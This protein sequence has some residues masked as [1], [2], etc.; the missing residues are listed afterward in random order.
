[1]CWSAR[2]SGVTSEVL[3]TTAGH[4]VRLDRLDRR[5]DK[6]NG[7]FIE[8]RAEFRGLRGNVNELRDDVNGMH[9]DVRELRLNVS[10]L[11]S[12]MDQAVALLRQNS[13]ALGQAA[14]GVDVGA[15]GELDPGTAAE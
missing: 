4:T 14:G 13:L 10:G 5:L 12:S 15:T 8:L 1:M 7:N 11:Q 3:T 6:L 2:I 9:K